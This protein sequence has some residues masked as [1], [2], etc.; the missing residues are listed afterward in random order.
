M[1]ATISSNLHDE[2]GST[3]SS[4]NIYADLAKKEVAQSRHIESINLNVTDVINKL[5][6]LVW[7]INPKYDSITNIISRIRSY[8]EPL[9]QAREILLD[10]KSELP[11][12]DIKLAPEIKHDIYLMTKELINNAIKHSQ[13]RHIHIQFVVHRKYLL[14]SVED[15]GKGFDISGIRKNRNGLS[16][17][18]QRVSAMKGS[19]DTETGTGSGT[20]TTIHIPV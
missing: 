13:C 3:L 2:I 10:V 16:N 6:D 5:D 12:H 9:A 14:V 18:A 17:I 1:R 8:A 15:D 11:E 7:G 19:L 4:I 20:K